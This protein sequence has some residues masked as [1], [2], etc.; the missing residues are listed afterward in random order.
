MEIQEKFRSDKNFI[1]TN[2]N[3][4]I[5]TVLVKEK[6]TVETSVG[7]LIPRFTLDEDGR[8]KESPVK[9][10][11]TG[12]LKSLPLEDAT[13]IQTSVGVIK[14]ELAIFYK[15]GALYR[16]FP[17]NGQVTG[18]WTEAN[19]Y[20]YA[21]TVEIPTSVGTLKVKPIYLQFYETGELESVLFW[22]KERV[23]ITT[24]AGETLIRKGICFHKNG[25]VKGF[26]PAKKTTIE[27]PIGTLT[28]FDPDP[29]GMLAEDHSVKFK[30]DG[31]VLSAIT[32]SNQITATEEGAEDLLFSPKT[33]M[34]YCNE[35]A[36]FI[37]PLKIYFGDDALI[38]SYKNEAEI[39]V[40]KSKQFKVSAYSPKKEISG[41]ACE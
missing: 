21:E 39:T 41:I 6:V 20:E 32:S 33:V 37:S 5:D 18:F 16:T 10:Y 2:K 4:S 19:E 28:V 34:S 7:T 12:E 25:A 23:T 15:S 8:K 29:N 13:E 11:R 40:P 24:S 31:T 27:S 9:F 26:E 30:E 36:F 22:P 38:F 17:L 35:D 14:T 3:G 1:S